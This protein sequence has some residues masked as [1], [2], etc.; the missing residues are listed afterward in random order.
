MPTFDEK[1]ADYY[2]ANVLNSILGG[3]VSS[4]LF[5]EAREK[6]GFCYTVYSYLTH[7]TKG[8]NLCAYASTSPHKTK[9]LVQVI[10]Q[11]ML[12]L[13]EKEISQA[14]IDRAKQQLKGGLLLGMEN[15][16]NMMNRLGRME[17]GPRDIL[18]VEETVERVMAV[19]QADIRRVAKRL[20]D[21]ARLVLA[22]VGPQESGFELESLL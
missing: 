14:E 13:R 21:P 12:D 19:S 16:S 4:R 9:D 10:W 7:Y 8:G 5:Q 1:D 6:R 15:S 20:F 11:Q 3:G 18:T 17:L 22:E 2:P